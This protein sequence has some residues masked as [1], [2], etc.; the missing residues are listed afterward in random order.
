MKRSGTIIIRRG[1]IG[2]EAA[3]GKQFVNASFKFTIY[4]SYQLR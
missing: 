1:K 4:H 3:E 2:E